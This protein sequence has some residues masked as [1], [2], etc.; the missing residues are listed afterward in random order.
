MKERN[1]TPDHFK[2]KY[3]VSERVKIADNPMALEVLH[4]MIPRQLPSD[5]RNAADGPPMI[6]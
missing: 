4:T 5:E 2:I 1:T 6:D 3:A